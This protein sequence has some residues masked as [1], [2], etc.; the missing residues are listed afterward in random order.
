MRSGR[1]YIL[2]VLQMKRSEI[3]GLRGLPPHRRRLRRDVVEV[4]GDDEG[5]DGF[6]KVESRGKMEDVISEDAGFVGDGV[7]GDEVLMLRGVGGG[8]GDEEGAV[9]EKGDG[10]E[11]NGDG[12]GEGG[13]VEDREGGEVGEGDGDGDV[14]KE[15]SYDYGDELV[16]KTTVV[17]ED[18]IVFHR[19]EKL[20][21]P[22]RQRLRQEGIKPIEELTFNDIKVYN[23]N[24]LRAY[25]FIYGVKRKTKRQMEQDMA[26][27]CSLFHP[28]DPEYDADK[29]EPIEYAK[30]PV[31][32][33]KVAVT[34]R[35]RDLAAGRIPP[36]QSFK[37]NPDN[38]TPENSLKK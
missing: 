23:R 9:E 12:E 22:R 3:T 31:P 16:G 20:E 38:I 34:K 28:G 24:Q 29:Y 1:R 27:Y 21:E 19:V 30:G 15:S 8:G 10:G 5:D 6:E 25:C 33:R 13:D 14:R 26:R 17:V 37:T 18:G 36:V 2:Y 4:E 35:E 32:R 11:V 7:L